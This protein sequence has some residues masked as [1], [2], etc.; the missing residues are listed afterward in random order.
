ML[1]G[2]MSKQ[3]ILETG[4]K[5]FLVNPY[6][7]G[8]GGDDP[9][10]LDTYTGAQ[11]AF[12]LRKLRSAYAGS[13]IRVRRSSDNTEQ[14]IGFSGN[15]LDTA[16]MLSFCGAGDGFIRT[17]YDQTANGENIGQATSGNQPQI[18]A[19]GAVITNGSLPIIDFTAASSH[20]L[21]GAT[22]YTTAQPHFVFAVGDV[23]SNAVNQRVYEFGVGNHF[24]VRTA[25]Y[26]LSNGVNLRLSTPTTN[27][28]L[29]GLFSN[30][31][32]SQ[33]FRNG[34]SLGTGN[35]GSNAL[36]GVLSIS[37]ASSTLDGQ[38]SEL[39]FYPSDQI[40]NRAGIEAN[41]NAYHSIY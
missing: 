5:M 4:N 6:R 12:G 9:L 30:S 24:T 2:K 34:T 33:I 39:I 29:W 20:R 8:G 10:L 40:S 13:C 21:F 11:V 22:T 23:K 14:D 28:E 26:Q 3:Q 37:G 18:V 27:R 31:A 25:D 16:A 7:L 15:A 1:A 41:I 36:N 38:V 19:S 32:S 35:S 17:W